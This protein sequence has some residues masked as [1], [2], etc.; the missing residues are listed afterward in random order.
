MRNLVILVCSAYLLSISL[1]ALGQEKHSG[2]FPA[3]Q[4]SGKLMHVDGRDVT[5]RYRQNNDPSVFKGR[6]HATCMLP[7][8]ADSQSK[9]LDLS[10]VP[11]GS[12]LTIFYVQHVAG[13]QKANIILAVRLDHILGKAKLPQA[14]NIPCIKEGQAGAAK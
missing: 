11:L 3:P 14:V 9:P 6:I 1:I 12:D 5:I 4:V 2:S 7:A 13:E 10:I 8:T